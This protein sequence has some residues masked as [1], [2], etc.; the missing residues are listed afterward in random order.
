MWGVVRNKNR[1]WAS[2]KDRWGYL[3]S[4]GKEAG[5]QRLQAGETEA[6]SGST[7]C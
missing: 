4:L 3:V 2:P 7:S 6:E 5:S 1:Y